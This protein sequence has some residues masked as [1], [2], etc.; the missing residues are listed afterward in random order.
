[1]LVPVD[2]TDDMLVAFAEVWYTKVRCI[3]DCE[4]AD[5]YAAM[6]RAAPEAHTDD[7]V[8]DALAKVSELGTVGAMKWL[9]CYAKCF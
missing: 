6:L 4:M 1:M 2:L 9:A 3:D 5:C 7:I 8:A